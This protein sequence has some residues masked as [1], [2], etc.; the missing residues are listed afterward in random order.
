MFYSFVTTLCTDPVQGYADRLYFVRSY[1]L[2][3]RRATDFSTDPNP[4]VATGMSNSAA[5]R[6][7]PNPVDRTLAGRGRTQTGFSARST[8][9]RP[10]TEHINYGEADDLEVW[11]VARA[12][13]AADFYFRP[14]VVGNMS[15]TDSGFGSTNNPTREAILEM[16]RIKSIK[17]VKTVVSVGTA[18]KDQK[19]KKN[20]IAWTKGMVNRHANPEAV[21]G[22][23]E[24]LRTREG[25]DYFRLNDHD[26]NLDVAL[27]EWEPGNIK[28]RLSSKAPGHKTKLA[29]ETAWNKWLTDGDNLDELRRCAATL[30][31]HRRKRTDS[32]PRW[33]RFATCVEFFCPECPTRDAFYNRDE[34]RDHC[35]EH[36]FGGHGLDKHKKEWKYR[37][38]RAA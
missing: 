17:S 36:G 6:N 3:K 26:G 1:D 32:R 25:F 37:R 11:Q 9:N 38:Q 18:R 34:F 15:L 29:I 31:E 30:V 21:H 13:T 27:D 16:D 33:E 22:Q 7:S 2:R 5:P 14:M 23:V 19:A 10:K 12:A 24:L 4:R 20:I 8:Q 35:K 28:S